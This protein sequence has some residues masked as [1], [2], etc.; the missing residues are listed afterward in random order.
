MRATSIISGLMLMG[1]VFLFS[2]AGASTRLTPHAAEYKVKISI[3]GGRLST[4]LSATEEGYEANYLVEPKG[5]AAIIANGNIE[6]TSHFVDTTIGFLP[7]RHQTADSISD[8]KIQATL[9]FD[10]DTEAETGTVTGQLNGEDVEQSLDSIVHDFV[11]LQYEIAR[12]LKNG[13]IEDE[14][15]LFEPDELKPVEIS[16]VGNDRLKVPY[17]QFDVIGVRH[18]GKGSSRTT[19]FWFAPDLDYIPIVIERHRKGKTL[20]RAVL[21]EYTASPE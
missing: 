7:D 16:T 10:W 14:Y 19:T 15:I 13:T 20:F 5:L 11:T 6:A 12:D 4:R 1:L 2:N 3:L 21:D 8:D 18:Q 17:G 9:D